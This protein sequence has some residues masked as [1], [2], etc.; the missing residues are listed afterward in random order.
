MEGKSRSGLSQARGQLRGREDLGH[1]PPLA[2]M[3][4]AQEKAKHGEHFL[5][6]FEHY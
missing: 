2:T 4:G 1:V 5:G 6:A 3:V